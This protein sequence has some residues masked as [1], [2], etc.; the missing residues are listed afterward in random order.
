[1]SLFLERML[2]IAS[3][4]DRLPSLLPQEEAKQ[5]KK[6]P[7]SLFPWL[8]SSERITLRKNALSR[9]KSEEYKE[10]FFGDLGGG[11]CCRNGSSQRVY[12]VRVWRDSSKHYGHRRKDCLCGYPTHTQPERYFRLH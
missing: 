6:A 2:Q 10:E 5:R 4:A 11:R 3:T 8:R 1:M 7:M 9:P 12:H